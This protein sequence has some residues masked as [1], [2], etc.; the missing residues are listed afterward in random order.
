MRRNTESE[1]GLGLG[2]RGCPACGGTLRPFPLTRH[3]ECVILA[4]REQFPASSCY[5]KKG[6]GDAQDE[7]KF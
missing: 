1:V 5:P 2:T 4:V 6:G 3:P 7:Y